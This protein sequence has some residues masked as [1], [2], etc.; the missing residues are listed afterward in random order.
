VKNIER[1]TGFA[2]Q[3]EH[4][5]QRLRFRLVPRSHPITDGVDTGLIGAC[6][7]AAHRSYVEG[8]ALKGL[9]TAKPGVREG[10]VS[11]RFVITD[12]SEGVTILG[13]YDDGKAACAVRDFG[14]HKS[15]YCAVPQLP[16]RAL[17]NIVRFA[18]GHIYVDEDMYLDA[19]RDMLMLTN[20]FDR[21]RT[22]TVPREHGPRANPAVSAE[23]TL[24][25]N[26]RQ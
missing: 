26:S 13:R 4:E 11:P 24:R 25:E 6:E 5:S 2:V 3:A 18:G 7:G 9:S 23:V 19:T 16:T 12:E 21:E 20:T 22:V 17:R 10:A 15:I 14:T 8:D 1:I